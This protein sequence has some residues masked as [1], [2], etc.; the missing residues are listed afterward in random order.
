MSAAVLCLGP[1]RDRQLHAVADAITSLGGHALIVDSRANVLPLQWN[2]DGPAVAVVDGR[3]LTPTAA[4]LRLLP[5]RQPALA[6]VAA[7]RRPAL[8]DFVRGT[9]DGN[10]RRDLV[11]AVLDDIASRGG[12]VFNP[13]RAGSLLE[14]KPTQ[15]RAAKRAGLTVPRTQALGAVAPGPPMGSPDVSATTVY[16]PIRGGEVAKVGPPEDG[17]PFL[18]QPRITGRDVRVLVIDHAIHAASRTETLSTVD[19]RSDPRWS[20][21]AFSMERISPVP[22]TVADALTRLTKALELPHCGVDFKVTAEGDWTFLEANGSPV[23]VE[24]N[25]RLDLKIPQA[26]AASLVA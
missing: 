13:P 1:R 25:D 5:P 14:H 16:K 3:R 15:L 4:Y 21:G 17:R 23:W 26:L 11:T 9:I 18:L 2:L 12:Q 22:Q 6:A 8:S 10:S 19:P 24:A 20:T 7:G